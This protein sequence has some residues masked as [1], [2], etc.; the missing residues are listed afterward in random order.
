[1]NWTIVIN[2][3]ACVGAM[4]LICSLAFTL[5]ALYA[6]PGEDEDQWPN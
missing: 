6:K 1:M 3:L 5:W 4:A 2:G